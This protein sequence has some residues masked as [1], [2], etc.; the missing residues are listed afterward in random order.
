M[1]KL[2]TVTVSGKQSIFA[3]KHNILLLC[4]KFR[5]GRVKLSCNEF[6]KKTSMAC[7]FSKGNCN[8]LENITPETVHAL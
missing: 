2:K 3:T 1:N 8:S 5:I 6:W 7:F 4:Y